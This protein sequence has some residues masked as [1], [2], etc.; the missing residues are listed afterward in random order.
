MRILRRFL[1]TVL[2][3]GLA[4]SATAAPLFPDVPDNHWAKDAVSALAAKGLV[5]GYPDGTF[6]G[7]RAA[8]RW[9]TAMIVARLLAKMEQAHETFATKAELDEV[10]KLANALREELDALG[11]RVTALEENVGLIDRRVTELERITFYGSVETRVVMQSFS[12]QGVGDNDSL[13]NGGGNPSNIPF[14]NYNTAVGSNVGAT[15]RPQYNGIFPVVDYRL[16]KALTNGTGFT[17]LGILGLHVVVTPDIDAGVEFS[18]FSSQG[19]QNVDAYWGVSAPWLSNIFTGNRPGDGGAQALNHS[20]YTRMNLDKFW[21]YHKPSKTRVTVGQIDRTNTDPIVFAGQVNLGVYGP[22]RWAGYGADVTGEVEMSDD[23]WVEW[24]VFRTQFGDG[25]AFL[26]RNY[27]NY[28]LGGNVGYHFDDDAGKIQFNYVRT[29][30]EGYT[31][32]ELLIGG[33]GPGG[34]TPGI[35]VPYGASQGWSVRQWVNPPGYFAQQFNNFH[36]QNAG[37]LVGGVF[38]PNTTDKRPIAGWNGTSDNAIGF[39]P[40]GGGGNFGPQTQDVYGVTGR[41]RW[42]LS[43]KEK[44]PSISL[45]GEWGHSVFKPNKNSSYDSSGDAIRFEVGTLLIKDTLDLGIEYLSVDP[46][47]APSSWFGNAL[48]ARF[49]RSMNFTGVWHQHDFIKYPHNR[50][51]V[52]LRGKWKFDESR[53]LL[54]AKAGFLDQKKTSLYDVRVT[55]GALGTGTP[56]NPVL[57]FSPG[58]VDPIFS[59]FASPYIYG[60]GSGN[61][62][63]NSLAPLENP[64]GSENSYDFGGSYRWDDPGVKISASYGHTNF[65]RNSSLSPI[66]GGDQNL[67]NIDVDTFNAEVQWDTTKKLTLIGGV[68]YTRSAGHLDPAGLYHSY[69]LS[70]NSNSFKNLDSTQTSPYLG[71]DYDFTDK[72]AVGFTARYYNTEDGVDPRVR[73]GTDLNSHGSSTHPFDWNGWQFGT[74]FNMKF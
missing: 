52:R 15:R 64:S 44:A 34:G 21:V 73:A 32:G 69:A 53:G 18:A 2:V 51:G 31:G 10:R 12:N 9:E 26:G 7:D 25:D 71:V 39:N 33:F 58:Y 43:D 19:D 22:R 70:I 24:E 59:G 30:D 29:A 36:Q 40:A 45:A 57:G 60:P 47:Y 13:R 17:S 65:K 68:D 62:F 27:Q 41:Y 23:S 37:Q 49:P 61:S 16:G 1:S 14:L 28:N 4:I 50:E 3:A 56:T 20:P 5:E 11:V 35:N 6:K 38:V 72:T 48:G 8:S 67:V 55:P 42:M 54:W 74:Q 63:T 66:F 46:N